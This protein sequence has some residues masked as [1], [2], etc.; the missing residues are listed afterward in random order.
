M[1]NDHIPV[2]STK[3]IIRKSETEGIQN[4]D[5]TG[6]K[7]NKQKPPPH[8]KKRTPDM[9]VRPGAQEEEDQAPQETDPLWDIFRTVPEE[10][11]SSVCDG[12]T[13]KIFK[14]LKVFTYGFLFLVLIISIIASRGSLQ[15][16]TSLLGQEQRHGKVIARELGHVFGLFGLL[17]KVAPRLNPLEFTLVTVTVPAFVG[18][19]HV[20]TYYIFGKGWKK[21][22]IMIQI[23]N[24]FVSLV[25]LA[26]L[27]AVPFI[28]IQTSTVLVNNTEFIAWEISSVVL[29]SLRWFET[30]FSWSKADSTCCSNR[31]VQSNVEESGRA[32]ERREEG[33]S[34][35]DDAL[36]RARVNVE[37]MSTRCRIIF[38]CIVFPTIFCN[39][40][41]NINQ[42]FLKF[43]RQ[44]ENVTELL[45]E[46]VCSNSTTSSNFTTNCTEHNDCLNSTISNT[47]FTSFPCTYH[48]EL[49]LWNIV[50]PY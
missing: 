11:S 4:Q 2:Y 38:A 36:E 5:K 26:F 18:I 27:L 44:S 21:Q 19:V 23:L 50:G 8:E 25:S 34:A 1:D 37:F 29:L 6:T 48:I 7:A 33:E 9:E 32:E 49:T 45:Y 17:Y 31:Q 28:I 30:Y 15:I 43:I 10:E 47:S 12:V 20:V 40:I 22:R 14:A 39:G 42:T 16:L 35:N 13:D 41:A 24:I 3:S 46:T